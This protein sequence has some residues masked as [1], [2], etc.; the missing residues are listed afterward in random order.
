[1]TSRM[2]LIRNMTRLKTYICEVYFSHCFTFC[3]PEIAYC[4]VCFVPKECF[5]C[6]IFF[7]AF[8]LQLNLFT[9]AFLRLYYVYTILWVCLCIIIVNSPLENSLNKLFTSKFNFGLL[10]YDAFDEIDLDMPTDR[11]D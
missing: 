8:F 5:V 1:M 9:L 7:L 3:R 6:Q 10:F 11:N 4:F 2:L